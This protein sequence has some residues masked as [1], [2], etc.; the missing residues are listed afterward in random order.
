M[1]LA[2]H[3]VVV[4]PLLDTRFELAKQRHKKNVAFIIWEKKDYNRETLSMPDDVGIFY[5]Y[6]RQAPSIYSNRNNN[7]MNWDSLFF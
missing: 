3:P 6:L 5:E 1:P 4:K 7:G 2:F